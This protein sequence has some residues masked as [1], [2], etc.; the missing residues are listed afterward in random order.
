MML[1]EVFRMISH[2]IAEG[3]YVY[4]IIKAKLAGFEEFV[5]NKSD[6]SNQKD[7]SSCHQSLSLEWKHVF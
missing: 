1:P 5:Y 7:N 6:F 4:P 2:A 3:S